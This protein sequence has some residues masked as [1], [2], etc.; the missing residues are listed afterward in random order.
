MAIASVT[1]FGGMPP[2]AA[3]APLRGLAPPPSGLLSGLWLVQ[4][5]DFDWAYGSVSAPEDTSGARCHW[6]WSGDILAWLGTAS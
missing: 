6:R 2:W 3:D 4:N 5:P 1:R